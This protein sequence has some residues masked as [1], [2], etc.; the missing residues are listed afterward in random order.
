MTA[1][2]TQDPQG[3]ATYDDTGYLNQKITPKRYPYKFEIIAEREYLLPFGY[4]SG[5]TWVDSKSGFGLR[6]LAVTRR[7]CY[8]LQMTQLDP[9]YVYS[10]RVYYI[11]KETFIPGGGEFYD[12]KGRLYRTYN[13]TRSFL[14]ECG[15]VVSNGT[16]AWQ[17]DYLDVHS[18]TQTLTTMPARYQRSD[19]NLGKLVKGK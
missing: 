1:T 4:N 3:D 13:I 19:F 2:D 12:Q 15:L 10:K 11:D 14:P 7:P 6:Q 16:P 5:K 8:V 18:S 9:N 17:V